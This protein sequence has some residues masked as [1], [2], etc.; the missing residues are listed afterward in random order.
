MISPTIKGDGMSNQ[1]HNYLNRRHFL[2]LA[3]G[4]TAGVLVLGACA[5]VPSGGN[6]TAPAESASSE[7]ASGG[8]LRVAYSGSPAIL[9]PALSTS[10][11]DC[12]IKSG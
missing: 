2:K 1:S 6:D 3:G 12:A 9:D 5:P 8:T 10:N 11:E 7:P 4:A